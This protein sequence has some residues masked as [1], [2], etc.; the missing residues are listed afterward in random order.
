MPHDLKNAEAAAG[1]TQAKVMRLVLRAAATA[2]KAP[3]QSLSVASPS[4]IG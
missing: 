3:L 4:V 2:Q 1:P